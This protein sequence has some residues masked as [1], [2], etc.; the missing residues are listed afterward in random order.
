[1]GVG[2]D[3]THAGQAAGGQVAE[4]GEPA[5]AVFGAGDLQTE[6]LPVPVAVDAD[7]DQGVHVRDPAALADLQDQG[8][9]GDERVGPGVQRPGPERGDVVIQLLGHDTDLRF[10]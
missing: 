2:G 8:V 4:E 3:Q 6:D 1:V 5:G 7:C 10:R 9:G